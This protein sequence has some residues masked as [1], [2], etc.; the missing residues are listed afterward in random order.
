MASNVKIPDFPAIST[1]NWFCKDTSRRFLIENPATDEV[2]TTIQ[3]G[4]AET[5][6]NA[7]EAAQKA[8]DTE[9]RWR[10]PSE[11]GAILLKAANALNEHKEEFAKILC[12]ENGKLYQDALM[13][14]CTFLVRSFLYL[15]L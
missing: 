15:V 6:V 11:R 1:Y 8:F 5:T 7:I 9:W 10:S 14:D 2:I 13:F 4:D 3:A 12:M